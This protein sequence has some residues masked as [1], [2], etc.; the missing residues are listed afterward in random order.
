MK[1]RRA[2]VIYENEKG[3]LLTK[4][5][6][7]NR[8]LLPGG[9]AEHNEPRIIA[10]IRE[11]KEETD[12]MAKEVKFLFEHESRQ[13]YHKVFLIKSD[14]TE[15]PVAPEVNFL[16]YYKQEGSVSPETVHNSSMDI[17]RRYL[18]IKSSL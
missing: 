11:L 17:I 5:Y 3:I 9:H 6:D 8:W 14:D 13:Y 2:T 4:M 15:R 12:L 16:E 1:R 18:E 7:H 10:A